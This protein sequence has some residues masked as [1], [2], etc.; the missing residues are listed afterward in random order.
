MSD[1]HPFIKRLQNALG[2]VD[3]SVEDVFVGYS[4]L[5]RAEILRQTEL[6]ISDQTSEF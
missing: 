6:I 2:A 1:P 3:A 4:P 5:D